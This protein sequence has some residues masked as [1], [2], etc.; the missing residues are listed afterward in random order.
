ML[1]GD[2]GMWEPFMLVWSLSHCI[3]VLFVALHL[4]Q[5]VSADFSSLVLRV[6]C[7]GNNLMMAPFAH[8]QQMKDVNHHLYAERGCGNHSMLV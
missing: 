2:V 8:S 7:D 4:G 6:T 3:M 1:R 5:R